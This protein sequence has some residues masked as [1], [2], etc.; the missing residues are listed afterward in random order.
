MRP[1][2]P[3]AHLGWVVA[4]IRDVARA[5][6]SSALELSRSRFEQHRP[7]GED[8][9]GS[10][11]FARCGGWG[12]VR[13]LAAAEEQPEPGELR[14]QRSVALE[15]ARRRAAERQ[16]G[17]VE[18]YVEQMRDALAEAVR[19]NPPRITAAERRPKPLRT[20]QD[21]AE[22]VVLLSD[23]HLGL[24]VDEQEVPGAGYDWR[25]AARRVA[26]VC[27][28]AAQFKP[29]H[30]ERSALR[31]LLGGDMIEGELH[32]RSPR[33]DFLAQ[34]VD[35]ARQI[36]TSAIDYLRGHYAQV[37]VVCVPGNHG[38][39]AHRGPGRA[40]DQKWDS[41]VTTLY[42]GLEAI[43]R[44]CPDVSWTIPRAP[45][46]EWSAPG[47]ER[48]MLTHGD[49]VI[50]AGNPGVAITPGRIADRVRAA[51][52]SRVG[53]DRIRVLAHGHTHVPYA[54]QTDDGVY[55]VG[56]GCACGTGPFAQSIGVF[57]SNPVQVMWEAVPGHPVGDVRFVQLRAADT[58]EDLE[59][60][61][62][63]PTRIGEEAA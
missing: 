57:G 10:R 25:I 26:L 35:G 8:W 52:A 51:N 47:G 38:R 46:A 24:E 12:A 49:T 18:V 43:F 17:D 50:N 9:P 58:R 13:A 33:I 28:Q 3:R 16:L 32:G 40:T 21:P 30:R 2:D 61:V 7:D 44:D 23:L 27:E 37:D 1:A 45:W 11:D 15:N 54:T 39:W 59:Q 4:C 19:A 42:R 29:Q 55:L 48:C 5:R 36:L 14:E 53:E 31:L 41:L 34:Q 22:T 6:D 56:N 62:P 60:I 63:V 20:W